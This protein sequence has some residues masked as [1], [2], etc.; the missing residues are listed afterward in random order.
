[1]KINAFI[2][3][4]GAVL[5]TL[6]I[7][8]GMLAASSPPVEMKIL[9][10]ATSQSDISYLS[11]SSYL[12][13]LGTPYQ[14]VFV[15][16]L[17]PDGSGNRL[18]Q[19]PL[20]DSA[21]GNGLYQGIIQTDG[22]FNVCSN[23]CQSLLS[24]S[25]WSKLNNYQL[26]YKVRVVSYY[27]YP[28]PQWGLQAGDQG[29]SYS[30]T[31]PLNVS[32]TTAGAAVFPYLNAANPIPVGQDAS[33]IWAYR[34][35]PIAGANETTTSILSAGS[36]TVGV[37]HTTADGRETMALTMD[38]YPGLLHSTVFSYG[39]V[40]WV[41]RGVFLGSRRIYLNTQIDDLLLGN[42]LYAPTLPQCPND[43]SCPTLFATGD[44]LH[45]LA[46]WQAGL[47]ADPQFQSFHAT[48]AYNGIGTTWFPPSDPV[49]A[50][51]SSLNNKFRWVSHTWS[52]GNLDCY[53]TDANGACVPATLAQAQAELNQNIAVAPSLGVTL[54]RTGMVTPFNGGL[55]NPAFLQAAAGA[56]IQYI[57][58]ADDPPGPNL[59]K[60]DPVNPG[61]FEITRRGNDLFD[62]V[63][64]PQTGVY[65]CW[66]DE[67]NAKY[68]PN[69]TQPLYSQNET[70]AQIIDI[71]SQKIFRNN[72]ITYEPY[73]LGY[74]IDNSSTYDGT[75]SMFSDLMDAA[76]AKY[77]K[78]YTLP[79]ITLDMG[80]IASLLMGRASYNSSGVTGV[81]T[82]GVGVTLTTQNAATIPVTGACSQDSCTSYAGQ[83]QDNVAMGAHG[84]VSLSLS[85]AEGASLASL[86]LNPTSVASGSAAIGT[87][88]LSNAAPSGGV[89]VTLASNNAAATVP[90]SVTVAAGA[91]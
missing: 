34:A 89:T 90:A 60:V 33:N 25:D 10:L 58:T 6:G 83:L 73:P 72:L 18:S 74:H 64:V 27:T 36:Y 3:K 20:T 4:L 41:T 50:A 53:T 56:G 13:Q 81:Y 44:D 67:Y 22:S 30:Q 5:S 24:A 75:H 85:A 29:G 63:S 2:F 59:G 21:T 42:R 76:I 32:V 43:Q 1:M 9:L 87:V 12:R 54:D 52:H 16:S 61:I 77:K 26:Q 14:T 68:G 49:F 55:A 11:I 57:V 69:G 82:P 40:N 62:N 51:I 65:G 38:N 79:V 86:D 78:M 46:N 91:T 17:P 39:V 71:E 37:T 88:T 80:D 8:A 45:A 31:N 48:F 47:Q 23:T 70:Y 66:P 35:L 84:T 19:I 15:S 28:D 7:S